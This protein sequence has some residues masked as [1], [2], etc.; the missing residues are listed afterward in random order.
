MADINQVI[1]LGIG[2]P[3]SIKFFIT[4]GLGISN[5][6]IVTPAAVSAVGATV[7]PTV[8]LGSM[9][10][11]PTAVSAV[12]AVVNPTVIYGSLTVAPTAVSAVATSVDPTVVIAG[13]AV[14]K[15]VSV[16]GNHP[17]PHL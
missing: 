5:N 14:V 2:T 12:G 3:S 7:D 15:V 8:I 6:V 11:A 17:L 13:G 4:L 10:F 1:S 16:F 9:A